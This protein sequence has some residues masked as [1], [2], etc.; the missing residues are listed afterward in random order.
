MFDTHVCMS[1]YIQGIQKYNMIETQ[2]G[3]KADKRNRLQRA[4]RAENRE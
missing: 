1:L 4:G 2:E 3:K